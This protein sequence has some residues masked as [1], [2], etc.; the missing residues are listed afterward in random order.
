MGQNEALCR[1]AFDSYLRADVRALGTGYELVRNSN[2]DPQLHFLVANGNLLPPLYCSCF[3]ITQKP[4]LSWIIC[5]WLNSYGLLEFGG[6]ALETSYAYPSSLL[7][8]F[9]GHVPLLWGW[10]CSL[11]YIFL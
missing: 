9:F 11:R 5:L 10:P 4:S 6:Y 7:D 3:L 2:G 8:Q 1:Q